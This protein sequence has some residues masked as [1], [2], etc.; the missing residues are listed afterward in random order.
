VPLEDV[1]AE[2]GSRLSS[3]PDYITLSGSGEATLHFQLG[4]LLARIKTLTDIPVAVLTNGSLMWLEE[5][6]RE[7]RRADLVIPSLDAGDEMMFRIVNRPH[8]EVSFERM[9]DGL[10]AFRQEFHGA[11][12]LE[13]MVV[14]G[15]TATPAEIAKLADSVDRIQPDRVQLNTVTRPPAEEHATLVSPKQLE[16]LCTLFSSPAEVIADFRDIHQEPEF[17]GSRKEVLALLQR[18]PCSVED[19]ASGLGIHQNEVVKYVEDLHIH[20]AVAVSLIGGKCC[21]KAVR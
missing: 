16:E 12:W 10:V 13:V 17:I 3:R 8:E 19:I 20:G 7:L 15:H 4:D 18:R 6:R 9:L 2:L 1:V 5:M 21:Y 11:Y 14:G